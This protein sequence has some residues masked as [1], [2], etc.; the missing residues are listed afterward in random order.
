MANTV[1]EIAEVR[2]VWETQYGG[3][4]PTPFIETYL[5]FIMS[6]AGTATFA[7]QLLITLNAEMEAGGI[8]PQTKARL[9]ALLDRDYMKIRQQILASFESL[10]E[11]DDSDVTT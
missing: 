9:E 6:M 4:Y 10:F 1:L 7:M 2:R 5:Q 8:T 3:E 11:E